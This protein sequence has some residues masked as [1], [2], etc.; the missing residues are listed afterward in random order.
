[1]VAD[2][3]HDKGEIVHAAAASNAGTVEAA[4][5]C[6]FI[7]EIDQLTVLAVAPGA[8]AAAF[9]CHCIG[10]IDQAAEAVKAGAVATAKPCQ[11]S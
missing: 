6:Q 1:M 11:L 5:P 4:E 3:C 9:A 8:V 2:T 10:L 7:G